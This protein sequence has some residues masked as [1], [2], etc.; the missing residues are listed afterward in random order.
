MNLWLINATLCSSIPGK[1]RRKLGA[2]QLSLDAEEEEEKKRSVWLQR[3][4]SATHSDMLEWLQHSQCLPVSFISN[5]LNLI[6]RLRNRATALMAA[7]QWPR[8]C[9]LSRCR[10]SKS[11][12]THTDDLKHSVM[13]MPILCQHWITSKAQLFACALQVDLVLLSCPV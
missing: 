2:M 12:R 13:V 1:K 5:N 9:G 11:M 3:A 4:T 6:K 7:F 10:W 8:F